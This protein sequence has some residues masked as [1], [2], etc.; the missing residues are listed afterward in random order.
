MGQDW[1]SKLK[2]FDSLSKMRINHLKN[3]SE[4]EDRLSKLLT[5]KNST[6]EQTAKLKQEVFTLQQTL[7]ECEKKIKTA[8]EQKGHLMDRGGSDEKI[9]SFQKELSTLE[10]QGFSLLEQIE[11]AENERKDLEGFLSGLEKTFQEI[12]AEVQV[13]KETENKA[14]ANLD[15]RLDLLKEELPSE[16]KSLLDK[17]IAKKL[18]H[19]PFTR[20]D[21]G[22]CFFCRFKISRTD[23]SEIDMQKALKVCPQCSRIFIPYGT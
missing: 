3:L 14:I 5:R 6:L 10:D 15:L 19:G 9:A 8:S 11:Q 17:T 18:A 16:Y 22:S 7:F 1:F 4:Q 20:T 12:S 2:E 13:E 21:Q 23:E